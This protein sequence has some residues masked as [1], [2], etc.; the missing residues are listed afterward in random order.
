MG[1]PSA[2]TIRTT[3]FCGWPSSWAWSALRSL[4][5]RYGEWCGWSRPQS[6]TLWWLSAWRACSAFLGTC[7]WGASLRLCA[8]AAYAATG[9]LFAATSLV[10]DWEY[11][12]GMRRQE[13]EPFERAA[14]LFPLMRARRSGPAYA[15]VL[16]DDD[17]DTTLAAVEQALRADP[18]A[19]DLHYHRIRLHLLLGHNVEYARAVAELH[20]LAPYARVVLTRRGLE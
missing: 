2:S 18:N 17:P 20:R 9:L 1:S 8:L 4:S 13:I 14:A 19:M 16:F 12:Q 11:G 6:G 3:S 7:R 5:G 15:H 10:S